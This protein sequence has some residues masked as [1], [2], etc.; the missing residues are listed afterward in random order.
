LPSPSHIHHAQA[1][2]AIAFL[3]VECRQQSQYQQG[4]FIHSK[5][6]QMD[7]LYG[8]VRLLGAG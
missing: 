8:M 3:R 6:R 1:Q 4:P 2:E 5:F 7:F